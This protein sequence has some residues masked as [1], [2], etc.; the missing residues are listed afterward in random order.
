MNF[1]V[2]SD[3][4]K[5]IFSRIS[6][7]L[8]S[9]RISL[10]ILQN[11]LF[12]VTEDTL[13]LTAT[14]L[15]FSIHEETPVDETIPGKFTLPGKAL[16]SFLSS[17][18]PTLLRFE[19]QEGLTKILTSSGTYSFVGLSPEDFPVPH[20]IE[21]GDEIE[22]ERAIVEEAVDYVSF[23]TAKEAQHDNYLIG[24]LWQV[25]EEETRFVASDGHR[26][27]FTQIAGESSV[28]F[29]AILPRNA[30]EFLKDRGEDKFK[31]RYGGNFI[32]FYFENG[33]MISRLLS[34]PYPDY[35]KVVPKG[36][37]NILRLNK[38]DFLAALRRISIFTHPPTYIVK[39]SL[40]HE[41]QIL[42]ASSPEVGEGIEKLHGD[43][44]G[45]EIQLGF[46]AQYLQEIIRHLPGDEVVLH[47][48]DPLSASKIE[49]GSE[50]N[51]IKTFY[52]LMPVKLE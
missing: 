3:I 27:A 23:C 46:N 43:Y 44:E 9:T 29:D 16:Q 18:S 41:D 42:E 15:D 20:E 19:H 28:V 31:V 36:T 39:I 5:P 49:G 12:E 26:L 2:H 1:T 45:E 37:G 48:F 38:G 22:F 25:M 52:L 47:T 11:V 7:A 21:T 4:F 14:N 10:P 35:E 17:L 51:G 50:N 30:F 13:K 33:Y 40:S 34:G 32:G 6:K 8:P 24:I